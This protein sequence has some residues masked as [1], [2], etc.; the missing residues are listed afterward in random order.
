MN[1]KLIVMYKEKTE[2]PENT[3]SG[4]SYSL[5]K[6]LE[7]Y[8]DVIFVNVADTALMSY[9]YKIYG[10]LIN[11][12]LAKKV[13]SIYEW[14]EEK[15]A[16][17]LLS[18]YQ[19]IPVLEICN[20]IPITNPCFLYQDLSYANWSVAREH[21]KLLKKQFSGG[22]PNAL[23]LSELERK[24]IL[25][26]RLYEK[27]KTVFYM[28]NWVTEDMKNKYPN[29]AEKFV[30]VGGG[31][32]ENFDSKLVF[33]EERNPKQI[34]F[35]GIDFERKGGDLV[36]DAFQI[37]IK[38]IPDAKLV[39]IG[40]DSKKELNGVKWYGKIER[41]KISDIFARSGIFCM[42]SRFEAYG[43]VFI[44]A[45]CSG[46]P[47]IARNDYEMRYFVNN[48]ENGYLISSDDPNEL[49]HIMSMAIKNLDMQR[50]VRDKRLEYKSMYSWD[51]VAKKIA[52]EIFGFC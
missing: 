3:W 36:L 5:R 42:P 13:G 16:R 27:A 21:L 33:G 52:D 4:T 20:D 50:N 28:G 32:N 8:V 41:N 47:I 44:E 7:K 22:N 11:T 15:H 45:L 34:V 25:Q 23:P 9:I 17:K 43:L 46:L 12:F 26:E 49:A 2:N 24:I 18:P 19:G 6:A 14:M 31:L 40:S 39:I 29:M 35:C 48:G 10:K 30:H 1:N 38:T 37:L 51:G